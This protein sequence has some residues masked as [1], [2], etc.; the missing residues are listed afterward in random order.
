MR[1]VIEALPLQTLPL[2]L[3]WELFGK[4]FEQSTVVTLFFSSLPW[5]S[6]CKRDV[7]CSAGLRASK[8]VPLANEAG[9]AISLRVLMVCPI[10]FVLWW[11][12]FAA[13]RSFLVRLV[14]RS[15]KRVSE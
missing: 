13:R 6:L 14:A 2:G 8:R 5:Y 4:K 9:G 10:V 3:P 12:S 1:H 15:S 11:Q 7:R